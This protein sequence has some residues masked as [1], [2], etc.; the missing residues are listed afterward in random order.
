MSLPKIIR[1]RLEDCPHFR[2]PGGK[3]LLRRYLVRFFP[4]NGSTY[5]EPFIGRGNVFF[6]FRNF[7]RFDNW[8]LNDLKTIPYLKAL[9]NYSRNPY[10]LPALSKE[11][12]QA[13][14]GDLRLLLEPYN[15]FCGLGDNQEKSYMQYVGHNLCKVK[16][17]AVVAGRMLEEASLISLNALDVME[18]VAEDSEAFIYLDPPYKNADVASYDDST[19]DWQRFINILKSAKCKWALSE[20]RREDFD[21]AFGP[22]LVQINQHVIYEKAENRQR[23]NIECLYTN[24][25]RLPLPLYIG[26]SKPTPPTSEEHLAILRHGGHITFQQWCAAFHTS[27]SAKRSQFRKVCKWPYYFFDG[28]TLH[29]IPEYAPTERVMK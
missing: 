27:V 24:Y 13:T 17:M 18:E 22:P 14:T 29:I 5:C 25:R 6:M 26:S 12:M 23:R 28:K 8:I 9:I 4:T 1:L 21:A 7:G 16:R 19:V 20:Y 2:Y 15:S 11:E 10:P 3:A